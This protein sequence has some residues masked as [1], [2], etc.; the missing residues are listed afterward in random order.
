MRRSLK[1]RLGLA[2]VSL[3]VTSF[4]ALPAS[5]STGVILLIGSGTMTPGLTPTGMVQ[6]LTFSG[7]G[8][9]ITDSYAGPFNC[10]WSA[11][12]T[13]GTLQ[14]GSGSFAG[15]CLAADQEAIS[16]IYSRTGTE[17]TLSGLMRGNPISGTLTGACTFVPTPSS[18]L[19]VTAYQ[20][21]CLFAV[22]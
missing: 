10:T 3:G 5:A 17:V 12:D 1:V 4:A 16:G 18:G 14:Q 6:S 11:N 2:A 22:R 13:I 8:V 19:T 15:W 20:Q 9:A 7:I 21:Q